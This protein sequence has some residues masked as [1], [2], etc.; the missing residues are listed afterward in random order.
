MMNR[1]GVESGTGKS[2]PVAV[3][4]AARL[5]RIRVD[6]GTESV[7]GGAKRRFD[8]LPRPM[9]SFDIDYL[10]GPNHTLNLI[11]ESDEFEQVYRVIR[12]QNFDTATE[13]FNA[14]SVPIFQFANADNVR[15]RLQVVRPQNAQ[16]S[17]YIDN[18]RIHERPQDGTGLLQFESSRPS[19][20][21]FNGEAVLGSDRWRVADSVYIQGQIGTN[22]FGFEMDAHQTTHVPLVA[23]FADEM[24]FVRGWRRLIVECA[25]WGSSLT[26]LMA[27]FWS[28][29]L[30]MPPIGLGPSMMAVAC[31]T[32]NAFG[33]R[34]AS[35]GSQRLLSVGYRGTFFRCV[36]GARDGGLGSLFSSVHAG[37]HCLHFQLVAEIFQ[38]KRLECSCVGCGPDEDGERT[39]LLGTWT[40]ESRDGFTWRRYD[41]RPIDLGRQV[42]IE[43]ADERGGGWG[44]IEVD[45]IYMSDS[46][47]HHGTWRIVDVN[48]PVGQ[49]FNWE[50]W[51]FIDLSAG[52]RF[53]RPTVNSTVAFRHA[54]ELI[55]SDEDGVIDGQDL[56]PND[57]EPELRDSNGNGV[58]DACDPCPD[59]ENIARGARRGIWSAP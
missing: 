3:K 35:R 53:I 52:S 30:N 7:L 31:R 38:M 4:M 11:V 45:D 43:L 28:I 32:G 21:F 9:V 51:P 46:E 47:Q 54:F 39:E 40:G 37:T 14:V 44:H 5:A 41:I 56:C 27:T 49:A 42:Q 57:P 8:G 25:S 48:L 33:Q 24:S 59:C 1:H 17:F 23:D 22:V 12:F 58:G 20:L 16:Y 19:T 13:G 29:I 6:G 10:E 15:I 50:E 26:S 34:P 36:L 18:L 2:C 55:D